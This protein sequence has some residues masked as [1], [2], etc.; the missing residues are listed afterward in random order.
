MD[1][2]IVEAK[3]DMGYIYRYMLNRILF[4]APGTGKSFTLNK[5]VKELLKDGGCVE[6]V[7]FHPDYSYA[8]F[9]GTYKPVMVGEIYD[10]LN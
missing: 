7:I 3:N 4:G 1:I 9:V 6:R 10:G 8:N 5:E 2:Q